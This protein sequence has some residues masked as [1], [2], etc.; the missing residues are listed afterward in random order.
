MHPDYETR[1]EAAIDRELKS[2]RDLPAPQGLSLRVMA[3]VERQASLPWHRQAWQTWP[4]AFRWAALV[5]LLAL[6]AG[7]CH[8]GWVWSQT[9]HFTAAMHK[10]G[11][12][13]APLGAVWHVLAVLLNAALLVLNHLST[14]LVVG[15]LAIVALGYALCFGLGTVC[16]RLAYTRRR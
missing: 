12:C 6:F 15:C 10:V 4:A 16:F 2:L 9:P 7:L 1:L 11:A 13:L 5:L 8:G 14:G 3:A